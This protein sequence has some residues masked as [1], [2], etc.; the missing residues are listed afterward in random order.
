MVRYSQNIDNNTKAVKARGSHIRVH[1]KHCREISHAIQGKN[2]TK[3]KIYL[4]NVLTH[5][6]AIPYTKYTGGIGRHAIGKQYNAPGDKVSF[7]EKATR[8][9][10]DLLRNIESNAETKGLDVE[11]V[12]LTHV[13]ANQAPNMRRRTYRAH[14]RIGGM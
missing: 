8:V 13:Q 3:A 14:G 10:L 1:Y 9:F 4:E 6:A 12:V 7:P 2:L 11:K 5:K